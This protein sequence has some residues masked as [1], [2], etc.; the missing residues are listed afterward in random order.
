MTDARPIGVVRADWERWRK[1]PV[2]RIDY[3]QLR[4][5]LL[6]DI[7]SLLDRIEALE[8]AS[9]PLWNFLENVIGFCDCSDGGACCT[10]AESHELVLLGDAL[11]A[12]LHPALGVSG[13]REDSE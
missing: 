10:N 6:H 8:A 11:G 1:S 2:D 9:E 5:T 7:P 4:D 12:V 13:T 3:I